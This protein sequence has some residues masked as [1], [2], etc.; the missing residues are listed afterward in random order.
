MQ[1]DG[2]QS[3]IAN[4]R[5]VNN[6]PEEN[7]QPT[8]NDEVALG[9][10]KP[11]ATKQEEQFTSSSSSLTSLPTDQRNGMVFLLFETLMITISRSPSR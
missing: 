1:K 10:G 2:T 5:S 11:V 8:H 6:L 4:N 7:Q 3:W 9:A